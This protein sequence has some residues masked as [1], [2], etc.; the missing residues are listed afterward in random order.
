MIVVR[1]S[2]NSMNVGEVS[3]ILAFLDPLVVDH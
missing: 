2:V 1:F 3:R